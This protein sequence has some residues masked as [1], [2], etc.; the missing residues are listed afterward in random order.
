MFRICISGDYLDPDPGGKKSSSKTL[1][2]QE[3][4]FN[5]LFYPLDPNTGELKGNLD[6]HYAYSTY[7]V[8]GM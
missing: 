5:L 6:P 1:T 2:L 4:C 8:C 7:I 3:N